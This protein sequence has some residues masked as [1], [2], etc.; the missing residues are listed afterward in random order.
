MD[1]VSRVLGEHYRE[2]FER[3]GPTSSGVDWGNHSDRH[4]LRVAR[5]LDQVRHR[6]VDS[7]QPLSLLDVGCGYGATRQFIEE[8]KIDVLYT[9]I[10]LVAEMIDFARASWPTDTWI[11]DDFMSWSPDVAFDFVVCNGVLTQ[12]LAI[13]DEAMSDFFERFVWRMWSACDVGI[14][15]NVMSSVANFYAPN[16]YYRKPDDVLNWCQ[17]HLSRSLIIDHGYGLYEFT[18][19]VLRE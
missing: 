18:V 9:G 19:T 2:T 13:S 11:Q 15:F 6:V 10:D 14:T 12:K 17:A 16:L 7:T 8:A 5:S 3:Y 1:P 4:M